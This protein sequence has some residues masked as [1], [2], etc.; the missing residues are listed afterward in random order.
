M[1]QIYS[2]KY[3]TPDSLEFTGFIASI[4]SIASDHTGI[5]TED[6]FLQISVCEEVQLLILT[7]GQLAIDLGN[8]STKPVLVQLKEELEKI[9]CLEKDP[10][11]LI[12]EILQ[13]F[14]FAWN[15][16]ENGVFGPG[17]GFLSVYAAN[18]RAKEVVHK[19][20]KFQGLKNAPS[21][22]TLEEAPDGIPCFTGAVSGNNCFPKLHHIQMVNHLNYE[23]T[24]LGKLSQ[25]ERSKLYGISTSDHPVE[26][27]ATEESAKRAA[28]K[29]QEIVA[30]LS[31]LAEKLDMQPHTLRP[32][33]YF[34][35]NT[36]GITKFEME[37][38]P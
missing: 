11:S 8:G 38:I 26:T 4:D 15:N 28:R 32:I 12:A 35:V 10:F 13:T 36:D 33:H 14:K 5:R 22:V 23:D 20:I 9:T 17:G 34:L 2:Q 6:K 18:S 30:E 29:C 7:T 21:V 24:H 31:S 1:T 19:I 27:P 3:W 16:D 37:D 25:A